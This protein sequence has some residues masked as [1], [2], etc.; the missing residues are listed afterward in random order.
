MPS[1]SQNNYKGLLVDWYDGLLADETKDIELYK[2]IIADMDHPVLE[3]ACGTGRHI[4]PLRRMGIEID[5]VDISEEMLKVCYSK[6]K[7]ENLR[8]GLYIQDITKLKLPKK[9]KTI[10]IS[11]ASFQLITDFDQ[12]IFTLEKIYDHLENDGILVLDLFTPYQDIKSGHDGIWRITRKARNPEGENLIVHQCNRYD[13]EEQ[14]IF[15]TYKYELYNGN[16][17]T[18]TFLDEVNLRWYG[19]YEFKL[20]LEDTGFEE[21]E[22]SD[23]F[24]FSAH[25]KSMMFI[26]RKN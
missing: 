11:G 7:K 1:S 13:L 18:E 21:V 15:G 4:V 26:A 25:N 8:A 6:L 5:G 12:A 24:I 17:L 23:E 20:M 14:L 10:F 16:K 22:I 3:L 9:Y 2:N 19:K